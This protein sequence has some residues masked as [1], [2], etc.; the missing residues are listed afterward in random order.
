MT[1]LGPVQPSQLFLGKQ[2]F[3]LGHGSASHPSKIAQLVCNSFLLEAQKNEG[4]LS[5]VGCE[6][7]LAVG[8]FDVL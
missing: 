3:P 6:L 4:V 2:N 1:S 7:G 5:G 8:S